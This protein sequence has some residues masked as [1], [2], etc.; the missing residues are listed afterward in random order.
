DVRRGK[1]TVN[2]CLDDYL[3]A[4]DR[5]SNTDT[6]G[7]FNVHVRPVLGHMA[8]EDLTTPILQKWLKDTAAKMP[9]LRDRFYDP[10]APENIRK[11]KNTTNS[12]WV[13]FL[14]ALNHA[15]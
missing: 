13:Y 1:Y 8:V 10:K 4:K 7:C 9:R 11:R 6:A 2:Q 3:A 14:A 12:R 5:P 15:W